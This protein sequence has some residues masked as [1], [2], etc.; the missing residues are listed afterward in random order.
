MKNKFKHRLEEFFQTYPQEAHCILFSDGQIFTMKNKGYAMQYHEQSGNAYEEVSQT[1]LANLKAV[2]AKQTN[3]VVG[4]KIDFEELTKQQLVDYAAKQGLELSV[5]E[6]KDNL[7]AAIESFL[8]TIENV[9]TTNEDETNE[10]AP[11]AQKEE[12]SP[13]NSNNNE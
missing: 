10:S 12:Y 6:K 4:D 1:E 11:T 13:V 8:K 5:K 9:A 7:I 3:E 2:V